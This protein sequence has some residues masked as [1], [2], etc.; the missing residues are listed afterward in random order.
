M[1]R[2]V[3]LDQ[4][5]TCFDGIADGIIID[6]TLGQGGHAKLLLS[7][8]PD[9][10]TLIGIDRDESAVRTASD[11]LKSYGSRFIPVHGNYSIRD[12][13]KHHVP[14]GVPVRGF[15]LDLGLSS[16]QLE[17]PGRGF[18]FKDPQSLDMRFDR[19]ES[20]LT[21]A[22]LVNTLTETELA[23]VIFRYGEEKASR[24]IARA[25]VRR[26]TQKA[27][28]NAADLRQ[29]IH[30]VFRT[31]SPVDTATRTFQALRIAVNNE[32]EYVEKGL[33]AATEILSNN[34]VLAVIS[35]HSLEDRIVKTWFQKKSAHCVCPPGLPVC[36]CNTCPEL[37]VL[38][39]KPVTPLPTEVL[40][41]PRA[42]SAKMRCAVRVVSPK[43]DYQ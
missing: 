13:W 36:Q 5:R 29:V 19:T 40:K 14:S 25:I 27:F 8:T 23:D 2:P 3:M 20:C 1:H 39:R 30:G 4:V 22:D 35:Y 15:L 18:S 26:R 41:N 9:T 6:G 7:V 28:S 42:R 43:G 16:T 11:N 17:T 12:T 37:H 24:R 38:T 10:V 34:G 21:A 32:L 33:E 31:K